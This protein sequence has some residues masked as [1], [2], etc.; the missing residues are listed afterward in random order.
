ME[1]GQSREGWSLEDPFSSMQ[2][3]S[4]APRG[5]QLPVTSAKSPLPVSSVA[6]CAQEC[7]L[8]CVMVCCLLRNPQT[9]GTTVY[10]RMKGAPGGGGGHRVVVVGTG[11]WWWAPGVFHCPPAELK[12]ASWTLGPAP[13]HIGPAPELLLKF[14]PPACTLGPAPAHFGHASGCC[15]NSPPPHAL[16]LLGSRL[17][18]YP[19]WSRPRAVAR[20]PR[21]PAP[22]F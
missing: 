22:E 20:F 12:L 10:L 1:P 19:P 15:V 9:T 18:P 7:T 11:G 21:P 4:A 14:P 17:R 3:G 16:L 6:K 5:L 13:V 8:Q 2:L